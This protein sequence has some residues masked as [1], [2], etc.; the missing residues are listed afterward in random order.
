MTK[1]EN[2]LARPHESGIDEVEDRPEV[3]K[4]VLD[5]RA[6]EGDA[7]FGP[8][9][10][11][12]LGLLGRRILDGLGLVEHGQPPGH[13]R[14]PWCPC[15]EAVARDD[16]IGARQVLRPLNRFL[17]LCRR[18]MEHDRF[19][20]RCEALD[21][22][23]PIGEQGG[24]RHEKAGLALLA[25]LVLQHQKQRQDL[26]GLAEPHV[27]GQAGSKPQPGQEMEPLHAGTLIG[28]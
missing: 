18:G 22:G 14:Q 16:Q 1:A 26:D 4:P 23:S 15:Q 12:R 10:L 17:A 27:V 11:D 6:G 21:L 9:L 13:P 24:R 28:S 8:E 7:G 5:G 25:R 20:A 19:E 2:W 3:A